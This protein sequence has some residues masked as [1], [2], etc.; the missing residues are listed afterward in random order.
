MQKSI[1]KNLRRRMLNVCVDGLGTCLLG[2]MA[3]V[4]EVRAID[5]GKEPGVQ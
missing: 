1:V 2:A 5:V 4:R 3:L